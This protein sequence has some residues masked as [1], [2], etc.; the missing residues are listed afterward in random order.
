ML[1]GKNGHCLSRQRSL[2]FFPTSDVEA[3]HLQLSAD[4]MEK[5]SNDY[6]RS[7]QALAT[8]AANSGD[9]DKCSSTNT[10]LNCSSTSSASSLSNRHPGNKILKTN[11]SIKQRKS[12]P[13]TMGKNEIISPPALLEAYPSSAT[14]TAVAA[15][16]YSHDDLYYNTSLQPA[17]IAY[18]NFPLYPSTTNY[19]TSP[20]LTSYSNVDD[21]QKS[22]STL[23][24]YNAMYYDQ[25]PPP[26]YPLVPPPTSSK[27]ISLKSTDSM[28]LAK[29]K[30]HTAE[31]V[32]A[33]PPSH[34]HIKRGLSCE[35]SS[36][37]D[38]NNKRPRLEHEHHHHHHHL[39]PIDYESNALADKIELYA[40]NNN[41][42]NN[43]YVTSNYPTEPAYH[44]ASVIVDSQ[45]Y[46]LN[47]WNG[48]TA[49]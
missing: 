39:A 16:A 30:S 31:S 41:N 24:M 28:V 44:H 34:Q 46:F 29:R 42:N 20:Y 49:F 21:E 9:N 15:A 27:M 47:G 14:S 45:Q 33:L 17:P 10:S 32:Q 5:T 23:P 40:T 4:Q 8:L 19:P 2:S 35:T 12:S 25:Q 1:S 43:G 11:R 13:K 36:L 37:P 7:A 48:A 22:Y 18:S 6:L 3:K 26:D 38:V